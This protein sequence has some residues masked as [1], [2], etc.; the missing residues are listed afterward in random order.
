MCMMLPPCHDTLLIRRVTQLKQEYITIKALM[1][2]FEIIAVLFFSNASPWPAILF[3]MFWKFYIDL[4][5][6]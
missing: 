2:K 1:G 5:V 4:N 6:L 3:K